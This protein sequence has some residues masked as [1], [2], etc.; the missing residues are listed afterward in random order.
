M[1]L[2]SYHNLP[3]RCSSTRVKWLPVSDQKAGSLVTKGDSVTNQKERCV[4][5]LRTSQIRYEG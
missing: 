2:N 4:C 1:E 3:T 5:R